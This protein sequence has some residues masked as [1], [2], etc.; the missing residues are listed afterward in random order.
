MKRALVGK[1]RRHF[2]VYGVVLVFAFQAFVVALPI[3][4]RMLISCIPLASLVIA[5]IIDTIWR[6]RYANELER[7]LT[8][9]PSQVSDRILNRG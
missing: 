6:R 1:L 2:D 9:K 8:K 4:S 5:A 7:R 3:Y